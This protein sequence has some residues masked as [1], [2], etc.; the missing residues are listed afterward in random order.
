MADPGAQPTPPPDP[1][2]RTRRVVGVVAYLAV[3]L[4]MGLTPS[5]SD[6]LVM[7][8]LVW[9]AGGLVW[10]YLVLG[11]PSMSARTRRRRGLAQDLEERFR[12]DR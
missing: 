5:P 9:V 12:G 11:G 6:L 8:M 7:G 10:A 3:L 2:A 4:A 1:R